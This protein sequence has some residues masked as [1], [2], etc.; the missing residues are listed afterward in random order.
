MIVSFT[1]FDFGK[2]ELHIGMYDQERLQDYI[3]KYEVKYLTQLLG[4]SLYA[5]FEA[6]L[7]A[8]GGTPT[9]QRFLDI[10]NPL[11]VDYNCELLYSEGIKEMLL[12]F[13]Y[14]EYVKD[15]TNQMT[16]VGNVLPEGEN[17]VR[18]TS[19]NS[20]MFARYNESA[21]N[22]K[23]IQYYILTKLGDYDGFN[24][25]SKSFAYWI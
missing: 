11:S 21:K 2:F 4:A 15:L 19:L 1:D 6:D 10:W 13:I 18:S 23:T 14:F 20:M 12:G 5:E 22:Y 8:G 9:E 17:S 24:G 3:D 16:P 7:S 25:V